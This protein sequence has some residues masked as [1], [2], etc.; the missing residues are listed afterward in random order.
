M[1]TIRPLV[2]VQGLA[3]IVPLVGVMALLSMPVAIYF[4]EYY[5]LLPLLGAVVGS[6]GLGG[7]FY[8]PTRHAP[9]DADL[10]ESMV[11]AASGWL[12]VSILGALPFSLV[13]LILANDPA[14]PVTILNFLDPINSFFESISGFTGTGLTM[15]VHENLLPHT[16]QWW[17]SFI[18]WI[19][20]VG[21][22]V[23]AL[24][25]LF[26][27]GSG[28]YT[29]YTSEAREEKIHPSVVSTVR[30]IWWIFGLYTLL[31]FIVLWIVGMGPWDA[32]NH[33]MTGIATG[34]FSVTDNSIGT[35]DSPLIEMA[36][37]PIM[38][39]GAVSFAVHYN[40][41]TARF[42]QLRR[43]L[44]T[45]WLFV[46]S[47]LGTLLLS[48]A[49]YV[50][51]GFV[52]STRVSAFQ[53]VSGITCTGFQSDAIGEWTAAAQLIMVVAMVGGGAAGSTAGGLKVIRT[54]LLAKGIGWHM[55]ELVSSPN[56]VLRFELGDSS[57]SRDEAVDRFKDAA[58]LFLLWIVFLFLGVI[59]LDLSTPKRF[60]LSEV[61][62]EVASAQSNVGLSAGITGPGMTPWNKIILCFNMWIGRLEI[63]PVLFLL[64]SLLMRKSS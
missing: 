14:T 10:K 19:G 51:M 62:F 17:R 61:V 48:G 13:A 23:L 43:D 15:T 37:L 5:T 46:Y 25:I 50:I 47:L 34:G 40:L 31:S 49:N 64:R 63:I 7:L 26:R 22:I 45:K 57:L 16:L 8:W 2:L 1:R 59:L 24:S 56:V 9:Q 32:L 44:Q 33:A 28:S 27:P 4:G 3:K 38:L 18:Q 35:Y 29:L 12:L 21:V 36:L 54:L 55:K 39:F 42:E 60:T 30:T 6:F 58:I 52:R 11:I 20:G 53:L 41:L